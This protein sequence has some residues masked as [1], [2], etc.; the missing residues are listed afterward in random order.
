VTG[1]HR[2][3]W[4]VLGFTALEVSRYIPLISTGKQLPQLDWPIYLAIQTLSAIIGGCI[5]IA[6]KTD[7]PMKAIWIGASWPAILAKL[8]QATP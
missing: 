4:G 7:T 5:S 6:W 2:F 1:Q 3:L 8:V